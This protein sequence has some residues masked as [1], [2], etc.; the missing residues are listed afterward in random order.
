M[1]MQLVVA[2]ALTA[3]ACGSDSANDEAPEKSSSK[4]ADAE[5]G[6]DASDMSSS[7]GESG[8]SAATDAMSVNEVADDLIAS[9]GV[10][11]AWPDAAEG[12]A[13]EIISDAPTFHVTRPSDLGSRDE[14]MPVVV[15]ANGGCL[16]S[17]FLWVPLFN[18]WAEAGFLVLS[19]TGEGQDVVTMLQSTT[20]ADQKKLIDWVVAQNEDGPYAGKIDLDRIVA[21][22]NSCGGVTSLELASQDDRIAAVFVLSGSSAVGSV[23]TSVMEKISVPVG[24]IV[25]GSEDI[26]GENAK[27]DYEAMKEGLPAMIVHRREGDHFTVSSDEMILPENAEISLNWLKLALYGDQKAYDDLTSEDVCEVCTPGDW[28]LESKNLESLL[29]RE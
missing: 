1:R 19:L 21:A 29:E 12:L 26:A 4:R 23:D 25:G 2:L 15:W 18:H 24:Y 27:G 7:D 11:V 10:D 16:R 6:S 14:G 3:L 22:G 9:L 28:T 20:N 17:D 5:S 13:T 8:E